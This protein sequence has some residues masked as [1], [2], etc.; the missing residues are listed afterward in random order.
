[1]KKCP[2]CAELIQD[3]AVKCRFCGEFLDRQLGVMQ[4]QV[5]PT[6]TEQAKLAEIHRLQR[7]AS[8]QPTR[9]DTTRKAKGILY[10]VIIGAIL[11]YSYNWNR[12]HRAR[13]AQ[14]PTRSEITFDAFNAIFGPESTLSREEKATE[15][16]NYD[17]KWVIWQGTIVY[18][19]RGE[20]AEPYVS[21]RH[22]ASTQTSDVLVRFNKR[23]QDV[24]QDLRVGDEI[25]YRGRITDYGEKTAFITLDDSDIVQ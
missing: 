24:L 13:T 14:S 16:A 23:K 18:I 7:I 15:F 5:E 25:R 1:M 21:I 8:G 2:F 10:L 4:G 6:P 11:F 3:D 17:G 22:L 12:L 9:A 20:G 19:N